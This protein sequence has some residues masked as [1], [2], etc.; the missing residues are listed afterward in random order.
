MIP[1][2]AAPLAG[3]HEPKS[4]AGVYDDSTAP[5]AVSDLAY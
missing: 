1:R 3:L 4:G 2:A 5:L